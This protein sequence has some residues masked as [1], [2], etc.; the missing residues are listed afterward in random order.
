M[1]SS[2]HVVCVLTYFYD[3]F[4]AGLPEEY[5]YAVFL[6]VDFRI[7]RINRFLVRQ[8]MHVVPTGAHGSDTAE[9]CGGASSY[10]SVFI[11]LLGSLLIHVLRQ[12]Q[13]SVDVISTAP[14][15]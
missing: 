3:L 7:Y 1:E 13:K 4:D 6:G 10:A 2:V 5:R 14:C 12:L 8:W 15:I 9:N 11:A